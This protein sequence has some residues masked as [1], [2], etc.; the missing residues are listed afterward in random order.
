MKEIISIFG[1]MCVVFPNDQVGLSGSVV[2]LF[3]SR[4]PS[5]TMSDG[6]QSVESSIPCAE[7]GYASRLN[8]KRGVSSYV[9]GTVPR[10]SRVG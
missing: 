4:V 5:T 2:F 1:H 9:A 6:L 7:H 10:H 3:V 8:A